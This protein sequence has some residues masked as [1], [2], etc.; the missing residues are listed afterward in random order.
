MDNFLNKED[1]NY[2]DI[3]MTM[4]FEETK[5]KNYR[6]D[7]KKEN[8]NDKFS[9]SFIFLKNNETVFTELEE[10]NEKVHNTMLIKYFISNQNKLLKRLE[11]VEKTNSQLNEEMENSKKKINKLEKKIKELE[12]NKKIKRI[13]S[14]S[15]NK[16]STKKKKN[17]SL[18]DLIKN[19]Q[20]ELKKK[21]KKLKEY[22]N[23]LTKD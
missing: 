1:R 8:K 16:T 2:T 14:K 7:K 9:P 23:L 6:K 13:F 19:L 4:K 15:L 3:N 5:S 17:I 11:K 22:K 18:M 21:D 12:K 20:T 10:K